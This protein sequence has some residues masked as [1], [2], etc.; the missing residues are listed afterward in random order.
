MDWWTWITIWYSLGEFLCSLSRHQ[1]IFQGNILIQ[2]I[3]RK[4]LCHI[5]PIQFCYACGQ[6]VE[7]VVEIFMEQLSR[8]MIESSSNILDR[9]ISQFIRNIAIVE[10]DTLSLFWFRPQD[11]R[12]FIFY[13]LCNYRVSV[14]Q[15]ARPDFRKC[16]SGILKVFQPSHHSHQDEF[17]IYH[18]WG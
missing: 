3:N 6:L 10:R 5:L 18:V 4:H 12:C 14:Y 8:M 16:A 9:Y 7:G 15:K 17:Q 13:K 2:T 11:D 1:D